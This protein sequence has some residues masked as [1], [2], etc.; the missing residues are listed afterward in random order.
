MRHDVTFV[1][2]DDP[3]HE[4]VFIEIYYKDK[5]VGRILQEKG[6]EN[7]EFETADADLDQSLVERVIPLK[8]LLDALPVA[9]QRL[10]GEIPPDL[11]RRPR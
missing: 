8:A 9:L 6:R 2:A 11:D 5:Y 1:V 3:D 10:R 4:H 7:E